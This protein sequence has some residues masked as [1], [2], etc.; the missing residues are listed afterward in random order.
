MSQ[1]TLNIR[2][3]AGLPSKVALNSS[4][5][6]PFHCASSALESVRACGA[7]SMLYVVDVKSADEGAYVR[8][9]SVR[10]EDCVLEVYPLIGLSWDEWPGM[11]ILIRSDK[12]AATRHP[13]R[14]PA[15]RM[16]R[17]TG[18]RGIPPLMLTQYL[19]A[20]PSTP[21]M[22]VVRGTGEKNSPSA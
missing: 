19:Q 10:C 5:T 2:S 12:I 22:I 8:I 17:R 6:S 7:S 21:P 3:T 15:N 11:S 14:A 9:G 18:F 4:R 16:P 20:G 1:R 13:T